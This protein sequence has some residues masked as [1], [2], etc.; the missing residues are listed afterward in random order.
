[1]FNN[2]PKLKSLFLI[3]FLL[4]LHLALTAYTS[5]SFL[6]FF[7]NEKFVGLV[8][9]LGSVLSITALLVAPKIFSKVGG[10]KFLIY[11]GLLSAVT[12]FLISI[13]H[14]A[15]VAI[16][17]FIV[18][19]AL[20]ILIV[21]SLD[22]L[23][24]IL[25]DNSIIGKVRGLYFAVGSSAWILAQL[26]FVG[27]FGDSPFRIV[28]L[29][30]CGLMIAFLFV[31]R[32]GL[33]NIKDPK[34]DKTKTFKYI[35]EFFRIKNLRRSYKISLLLQFFYC[36]MVVYTPIYLYIHLGFSWKE[37]GLMFA[38]ML[39]PFA[40]LPFHL[41]RYSDKIGERKMLMIG[42]FI[43][44]FATLSLFFIE[45]HEVWIWALAL[46]CTRIGAATI[47]IM[48]D[49]YFFKHI[50][51][52]NEEYIGVYRSPAP[53]AFIIG[54]LVA[55]L[56]FIFIPSFNFIYVLLGAVMLCGVYLSST[57]RKSDS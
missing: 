39:L 21:F 45:R 56:A 48:S 6:S 29:L 19:F 18:Y 49:V 52:E 17:A 24:K 38:I 51:P 20:N 10:Q 9:V 14:S 55:S 42:F 1:M 27:V 40:I 8:Y 5:S 12:L 57:I 23:L 54:P 32:V 11:V 41:G 22:E 26:M 7:I 16:P 44:S 3:N 28:Y 15:V 43:A 2:N 25:S 33:G 37:I 13:T 36:W 31:S 53:V 35:R 47:E 46:L 34:Y 50:K 30:A 4:S